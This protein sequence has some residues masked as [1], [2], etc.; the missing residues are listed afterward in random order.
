MITNLY[1]KNVRGIAEGQIQDLTQ[2]NI[3]VGPN[4]SGK[5]T[6][7]EALYLAATA[8]VGCKLYAK[9]SEGG[10]VIPV[11]VTADLDL[12][13]LA[14]MAR[15]WQRHNLPPQ[16]RDAPEQW[17]SAEGRI[18]FFGIHDILSKYQFLADKKTKT[19]FVEGDEQLTAL[20]RVQKVQDQIPPFPSF[21]KEYLDEEAESRKNRHFV[22]LW[23][24]PFTFNRNGIAGWY[25]DG[26]IP[27][28]AQTLFYDFHT[29]HEHFTQAFV[30]RGYQNTHRWQWHIGNHF[31]RVFDL[32]T[33]PV[34]YVSFSPYPPD[35]YR[36]DILVEQY[37][38][39]A[40]ID[41]WGDGARH[42]MKLLAPLILLRQDAERGHLGMVLW[43]D[44]ELFM[45]PR[46]LHRLMQEVLTMIRDQPIQL[47]ITTQSDEI[48]N[49]MTTLVKAMNLPQ[50]TLKVFRQKLEQGHLITS[51]FDT[52]NLAEWLG[53]GLDPRFW[54]QS[55]QL[56][57]YQPGGDE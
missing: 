51:W 46:A 39:M 2:V 23:H 30:E 19:G 7:L 44:P 12:L 8:D 25:V 24:P 43:E 49:T 42:A 27:A 29:T 20:L 37:G 26:H 50:D 38:K 45:H 40:S 48:L 15:I 34:P 5:T 32:P 31:A 10:E 6:V 9:S 13:G 41:L 22:L 18:E 33:D 57:L 17:D 35:P 21:V 4:N 16:W 36:Y 56:L 14:P 1:M 55:D 47:F 3:F 53:S 28:A 11:T 52:D 54:K